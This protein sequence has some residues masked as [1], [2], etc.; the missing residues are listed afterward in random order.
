MVQK[1][2]DVR[3]NEYSNRDIFLRLQIVTLNEIW[4]SQIATSNWQLV[5]NCDQLSMTSQIVIS[6]VQMQLGRKGQSERGD[7]LT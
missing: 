4:M 2:Q 7:V 3:G 6:N 5:T 1:E